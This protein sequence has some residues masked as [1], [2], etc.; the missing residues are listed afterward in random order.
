MSL[1]SGLPRSGVC[2]RALAVALIGLAVCGCSGG[3]DRFDGRGYSQTTG[4][5]PPGQ[6]FASASVRP[7]L[8]I[9]EAPLTAAVATPRGGLRNSDRPDGAAVRA[10]RLR[11]HPLAPASSPIEISKQDGSARAAVAKTNNIS[12]PPRSDQVVARNQNGTVQGKRGPVIAGQP[13]VAP[14][15]RAPVAPPDLP[16]SMSA[17]KPTEDAPAF[18]WPVRGQLIAGFGSTINGQQNHGINVAVPEDTSI[19]AAEGGIV[20]YAGSQLKSYGNLLL[21]RHP[22]GYV[23]V[24]AHAKQLLVKS[25]DEIKRGQVIAKSGR[26]GDVDTPQVH[27]EIRKASAPIDPMPYL[28]GA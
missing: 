13:P 1:R 18:H 2:A 15:E 26:S 11:A 4:S 25:G 3:P 14:A 24:Y 21:V 20:V 9:P 28:S 6:R 27:F 19:R 16:N 8:P 7:P 5:I 17:S 10:A 23:T 22:N 12:H